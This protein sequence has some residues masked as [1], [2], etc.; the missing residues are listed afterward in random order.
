MR[1]NG[2]SVGPGR[3]GRLAGIFPD[4]QVDTCLVRAPGGDRNRNPQPVTAFAAYCP[5]L[6]NQHTPPHRTAFSRCECLELFFR[7]LCCVEGSTA[8]NSNCGRYCMKP[9]QIWFRIRFELSLSRRPLTF[10]MKTKPVHK[11]ML[12]DLKTIKTG[13]SPRQECFTFRDRSQNH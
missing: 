9:S 10:E 6:G 4:P 8:K 2:W 1:C 13:K 7:V 12:S 11:A 3:S 5:A